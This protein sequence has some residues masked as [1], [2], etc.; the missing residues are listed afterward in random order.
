MGEIMKVLGAGQIA[1]EDISRIGPIRATRPRM[2]RCK[3]KKVED[4][5]FI[6]KAARKLRNYD[7]FKGIYIDAD[8]TFQQRNF[9]KTLRTELQSK[10]EA[11]DDVVIH[12]GKVIKKSDIQNPRFFH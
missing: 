9:H 5:L 12:H 6:L 7:S 1:L 11:G 10:R 3:C 4:K 2:L 8:R